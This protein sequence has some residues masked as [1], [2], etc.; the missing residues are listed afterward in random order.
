MSVEYTKRDVKKLIVR[1]GNGEEIVFDDAKLARYI[2]RMMGRQMRKKTYLGRDPKRRLT[3][4][5]LL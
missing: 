2:A 1:I 3:L 4:V 5:K